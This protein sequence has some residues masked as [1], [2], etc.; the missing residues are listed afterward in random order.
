MMF[1]GMQD[2]A[3][4]TYVLSQNDSSLASMEH[5]WHFS[6]HD[7]N[8]GCIKGITTSYDDRFLVTIGAD[9]NIFVFS[10]F[11]VFELRKTMKAK[12]PS[13]RVRN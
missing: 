9:S 5:Y 11:S 10:I 7:N 4:R 6:I 3:I 8:Y 1:C 12:V 13:P 2:G